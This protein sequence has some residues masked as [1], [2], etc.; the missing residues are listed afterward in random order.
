M[1]AHTRTD[2]GARRWPLPVILAA[3]IAL[4]AGG[5]ALA[6]PAAASAPG[7]AGTTLYVSPSGSDASPGTSPARPLRTIARA[8]ALVRAMDQD[9][10]GNI[11]VELM[12]GTYRLTEPLTLD[13]RDSGSNGYDVSW[14]AAPGA[15]PVLSGGERITGWHPSDPAK[16][17]WA[18]PAPSG[19]ATRQLY[20]NGVR[21]QRAAGPLP[22]SLTATA[23]GY[24]AASD[25]MASWR[26]PAD[27]EFVYP[28]GAGYWSLHT[29]GQGA[30]TE[31]R[32]PVASISAATITMAQPCW[33]NSNDRVLRTEHAVVPAHRGVRP[34]QRD[35]PG[36]LLRR[37][38]AGVHAQRTGLARRV[39]GVGRRGRAVHAVPQPGPRP[40]RADRLRVRRLG[41]AA[42]GEDRVH[43]RPARREQRGHVGQ[44]VTAHLRGDDQLVLAG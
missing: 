26:N 39:L 18:A 6:A 42:G 37:D 32:C 16:G 5:T 31:P 44:S 35:R 4:A 25:V 8:R 41:A 43:D 12:P 10:T 29:G 1:R 9:M 20:V 28:G 33:D 38:H 2:R 13:A 14:T 11:T 36:G 40:E 19:L 30:W 22:T 17:I 23:A 21:A 3:A 27:I 34:G 7:T 24:T 15:R